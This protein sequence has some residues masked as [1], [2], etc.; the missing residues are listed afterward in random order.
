MSCNRRFPQR[1]WN[2]TPWWRCLVSVLKNSR[3]KHDVYVQTST[4]HVTTRT[5]PTLSSKCKPG[6]RDNMPTV[7]SSAAHSSTAMCERRPR[8]WLLGTICTFPRGVLRTAVTSTLS[9]LFGYRKGLFWRL[10]SSAALCSRRSF[11]PD[12]MLTILVPTHMVFTR[13]PWPLIPRLDGVRWLPTG[14]TVRLLGY[15]QHSRSV[16]KHTAFVPTNGADDHNFLDCCYR[17]LKVIV[18]GYFRFN[19]SFHFELKQQLCSIFD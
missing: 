15:T 9:F 5:P 1:A 10:A 6:C 2:T 12:H 13:L 18:N 7:A 19:F 4:S 17:P 11:R 14:T 16:R 8:N 3:Q